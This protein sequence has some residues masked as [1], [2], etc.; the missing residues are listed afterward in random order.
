MTVRRQTLLEDRVYDFIRKYLLVVPG[1]RI[2]VAVSGGPD[3]VAL[4]QLLYNLRNVL[5]ISL[6]VAHLDH[7]LRG[8]ESTGDALYVAGLA[9]SLGLPFAVGGRDVEKYRQTYKMTL[10]EAARE[11]RYSYLAEVAAE[12]GAELVA[13]GHTQSDNVETI[14]MHLIRGT[15][16]LG[17]KGLLPLAVRHC[18]EHKINIIRPLLDIT[19]DEIEAYCMNR[20]LE[21]RTDSTNLSLSPFRNRVRLELL[22][23]LREYNPA[24]EKAVLRLANIAADELDYLALN[25]DKAWSEFVT[26]HDDI[27]VFER[28]GFDSLHPALQR[29]LLRRATNEIAGT[30]KD[31][32]AS[33]IE[34]VL[35]HLDRGA[36]KQIELKRDIV[37]TIEHEHYLLA[38]KGKNLCPYPP[39]TGEH[40]LKIPGENELGRWKV[41]TS[42]IRGNQVGGDIA[43]LICYLDLAKIT[44][45]L[46]MRSRQPGDRFV[47][48]GMRTE[49][50]IKDYLIDARVPRSWRDN[51]PVIVCDDEVVWLAG[52]RID[53]GFKV[54]ADTKNMLRIE[55]TCIS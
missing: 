48:M 53:D 36:G 44:T 13:T 25:R 40:E 45:G 7:N 1:S 22:P 28:P 42:V 12:C 29:S 3:S 10:E 34:D 41:N 37:F 16:T 26:R 43:P 20:G 27:I 17:L 52:Y 54:T 6:V 24:I 32:E 39:I 9:Q 51:I 21:T 15:G 30:L 31:I 33:H 50:K 18:G 47:P 46:V 55:M 23:L 19:R 4:L 49:K 2:V 35:N 38:K 8:D 11:V 14:L 5:K